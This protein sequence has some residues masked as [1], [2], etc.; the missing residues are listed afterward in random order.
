[1]FSP[2]SLSPRPTLSLDHLGILGRLAGLLG[3]GPVDDLAALDRLERVVADQPGQ[4]R[5]AT[6]FGDSS[7]A[8][9]AG[10]RCFGQSVQVGLGGS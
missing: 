6:A 3:I 2:L 10:R 1:M 8:S 4:D 7:H 9:N 5:L